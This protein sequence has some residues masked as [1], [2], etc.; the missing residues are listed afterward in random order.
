M[1]KHLSHFNVIYFDR[2]R[3]ERNI[4]PEDFDGNLP[5]ESRSGT[6]R[7]EVSFEGEFSFRGWPQ[8]SAYVTVDQSYGAFDVSIVPSRLADRDWNWLSQSERES[9]WIN[10]LVLGELNHLPEG[11]M[12]ESVRTLDYNNDGKTDVVLQLSTGAA[13]VFV[14]RDQPLEIRRTPPCS[15][16]G[17]QARCLRPRI[18]GYG[19]R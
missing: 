17:S 2:E 5:L 19:G 9:L 11:A 6:I 18:P 3:A 7:G 4:R 1:G 15:V 13:Y 8:K 12:I 10:E 16:D 14:Q